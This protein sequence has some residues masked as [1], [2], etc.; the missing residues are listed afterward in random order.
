MHHSLFALC[1]AA[2]AFEVSTMTVGHLAMGSRYTVNRLGF[3]RIFDRQ[4]S[5]VQDRFA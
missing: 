4:F 3:D 5:H 2:R 1:P